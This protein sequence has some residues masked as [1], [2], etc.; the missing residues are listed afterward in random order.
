MS[1]AVP[2]F[3][4]AY[5]AAI[6]AEENYPRGKFGQEFDDY[7]QRVHGILPTILAHGRQSGPLRFNWRRLITAEYGSAYAWSTALLV[8][9]LKNAWFAGGFKLNRPLIEVFIVGLGLATLGYTVASWL[10]KSSPLPTP[11]AQVICD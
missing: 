4:F 11:M 7:C 1:L 9:S 10:W 3:V 8:V 6:A 5:W 2:F